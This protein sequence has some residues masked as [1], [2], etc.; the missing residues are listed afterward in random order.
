MGLFFSVLKAFTPPKKAL[1]VIFNVHVKNLPYTLK[2]VKPVSQAGSDVRER[3]VCKRRMARVRKRPG[4]GFN[5]AKAR[6][7]HKA[8]TGLHIHCHI[9]V[10]IQFS[11][12]NHS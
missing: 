3:E 7:R 4:F 2:T 6:V 10:R 9:E 1:R 8:K 11:R 5:P 12:L